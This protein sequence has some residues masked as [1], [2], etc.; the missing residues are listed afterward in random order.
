MVASFALSHSLNGA[1]INLLLLITIS[2]NALA[3]TVELLLRLFVM[4]IIKGSLKIL[5]GNRIQK[6]TTACK[7]SVLTLCGGEMFR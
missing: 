4:E 2:L 1:H 6:Y 5:N 3:L 7:Y